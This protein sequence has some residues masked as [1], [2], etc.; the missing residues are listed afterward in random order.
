[1][2]R[3]VLTAPLLALLL[4]A[5][6]ATQVEARRPRTICQCLPQPLDWRWNGAAAV[7]TGTVTGIE[8]VTEW[9]QRGNDDI[10]VK[11]TFRVDEGFKGV[12]KGKTFLMHTNMQKHTC[13]GYAFEEGKPY[14]VF[15]YVRKEE[16]YERWSQYGFPSGTYDVGGLCGGIKPLDG[17]ETAAEIE[18]IKTL[19][20]SDE[21]LEDRDGVIGLVPEK[22]VTAH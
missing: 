18:E 14:L 1:M 8:T 9:V 5:S 20:K 22:A 7:F 16:S 11:V 12:E 4:L 6:A 10:P 21:M 17:A 3:I 13:T 15:A 2:R 19:P